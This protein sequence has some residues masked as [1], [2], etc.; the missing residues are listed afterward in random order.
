ML[1]SAGA[2]ITIRTSGGQTALDLVAKDDEKM[3]EL[4]RKPVELLE[5]LKANRLEGPAYMM[6]QRQE[7]YLDVLVDT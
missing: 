1:L 3:L 4:V 2:D 5:W 6:F 7:L